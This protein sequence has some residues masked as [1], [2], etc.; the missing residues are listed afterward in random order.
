MQGQFCDPVKNQYR[1]HPLDYLEAMT[2]VIKEAVKAAPEGTADRIAGLS[3]DTTGSTP[4]LVDTDGTPLGLRPEFATN[5]NALFILWKDHR[6]VEEAAR[7][8]DSLPVG[9][10]IIPV[11]RGIYSSEWVWAKVL[12]VLRRTQLSGMQPGHGSSIATGF[13]LC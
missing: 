6:A 3:F 13:R 11:R 2:K 10:P 7:S 8:I 12:H 9:K 1:Q 5:P 4:V